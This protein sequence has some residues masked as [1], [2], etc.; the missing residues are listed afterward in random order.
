MHFLQTISLQKS[1]LEQMNHKLHL[2]VIYV[3]NNF[4]N[5]IVCGIILG[6]IDTYVWSKSLINKI[7]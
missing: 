1:V 3:T 2:L 4:Y 7:H 6:I 5:N